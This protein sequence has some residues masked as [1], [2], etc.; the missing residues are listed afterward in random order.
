MDRKNNSAGEASASPE[1]DPLCEAMLGL[2]ATGC[3]VIFVNI[4]MAVQGISDQLTS[5][6]MSNQH[7]DITMQD[8][9]ITSQRT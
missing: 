5:S 7:E 6:Q 8:I 9:H 1:Y 2:V 3:T 4:H